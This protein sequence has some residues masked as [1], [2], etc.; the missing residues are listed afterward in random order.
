[1]A[2]ATPITPK[3]QARI[4][5]AEIAVSRLSI[6]NTVNSLAQVQISGHA[7]A[8]AKATQKSAELPAE[9][10]A[11]KAGAL[12]DY[13]LNTAR[14]EPDMQVS[15]D[16]GRS[17]RLL[18]SGFLASPSFGTGSGS[19]AMTFTG[20]HAAAALNFFDGSTYDLLGRGANF[21]AEQ[22]TY[23]NAND[24]EIRAVQAD[25]AV[26]ILAKM[27]EV[28]QKSLLA[29]G[30]GAVR[31][32]D[33]RVEMITA[34]GARNQTMLPLVQRFLAES[35]RFCRIPGLSIR[36]SDPAALRIREH[37]SALL[38]QEGGFLGMVLN[39]LLADFGLQFVCRLDGTSPGAR[40]ELISYV[41]GRA[42]ELTL[43]TEQFS[44]T[45]GGSLDLPIK[46]VVV[47]GFAA[48][49][50]MTQSVV[51]SQAQLP[52]SLASY[53][54]AA[55]LAPGGR[56]ILRAAPRWYDTMLLPAAATYSSAPSIK[57]FG[58]QWLSTA[59]TVKKQM[60]EGRK[61]LD[62]WAKTQFAYLS[63]LSSRASISGPLNAGIQA[64]HVYTVK[65]QGADGKS[66]ALFQG[67]AN[68]VTHQLS[69]EG[70]L[71]ASTSVEFT[72]VQASGFKQGGLSPS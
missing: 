46:G 23:L 57:K 60:T 4:R 55:S 19:V 62:W 3:V 43:P 24:P 34:S 9:K 31:G 27:L 49:G 44:F 11:A 39:N 8:D 12:Q 7:L 36:G 16:D 51:N 53:P 71:T 72:H 54:P 65:V 1:M 22:R 29:Y 14:I 52:E 6:T 2:D 25:N 42:S 63:L 68:T 26:V 5:G 21:S 17:G 40:L 35:A 70:N 48:P 45:A 50:A 59:K 18:F 58:Q 69:T 67:Y 28:Y 37:L 61:L 10:I 13:I 15:L 41:N 66:A 56:V 38:Q 47:K 64:G 20:V 30:P 33:T 32:D